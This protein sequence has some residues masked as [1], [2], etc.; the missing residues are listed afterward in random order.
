MTTELFIHSPR[1][2]AGGAGRL[3]CSSVSLSSFSFS[4]SVFLPPVSLSLCPSLFSLC[5]FRALPDRQTQTPF[6]TVSRVEFH[7]VNAQNHP[8]VANRI[9]SKK[10]NLPEPSSEAGV[11]FHSFASSC[12][13]FSTPRSCRTTFLKFLLFPLS[14]SLSLSTPP[15]LWSLVPDSRRVMRP[16]LRR[17]ATRFFPFHS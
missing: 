15:P 11:F 9:R 2:R 7:D 17:R 13:P 3:A 1:T 8:K 12:A 5:L 16:E 10:T 4:L 6:G 14:L